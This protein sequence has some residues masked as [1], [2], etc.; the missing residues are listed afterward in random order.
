MK[1]V[2][3]S[4]VAALLVGSSA[5]AIENTKVSGDAKLLYMTTDEK[6]GTANVLAGENGSGSFF[7]KDSSAADAVF[8]LD[9]TTDLV[10]NDLVKISA[11]AGY[12]V[13]TSLGLENNLVSN[14]WGG[15][16]NATPSTGQAYGGSSH[17]D[18]LGG[19]KVDNA[20]W[21]KEAWIAATAGKTTAKLGR[22][23]VDTPLAFSE[24]WSAEVNTFEGVVA[25]NQDLPD[26]TVV[27][28]YLGNGNG[29]ETFGYDKNNPTVNPNANLQSN[30]QDLGLAVAP[31][32]N[33]NGNFGTFGTDGAYALGVVNNSFKPLNVQAWYYAVKNVAD[34]YWL[35]ADLNMEGI[36]AGAQYSGISVQKSYTGLSSD[37]DND[38]YALMLGY[39]LKDT[40]T[41]KA[42]YSQTGDDTVGGYAANV[43]Y[44]VATN[45]G[46]TKLY[47]KTFWNYGHL[48]TG[49]GTDAMKFSISSPV[50]GLFDACASYTLVDQDVKFGNEEVQEI[51]LVVKKS[52]GPLDAK[53]AYINL[54]HDNGVATESDNFNMIQAYLTL[55]F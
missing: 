43:G 26:T 46:N 50:N 36:L 12:T 18:A 17:R 35:Q 45:T 6:G 10:S 5:F 7:D 9:V 49:A 44:N 21:F 55:N 16:H 14:V 20:N 47:T 13:L 23:E 38:V 42:A 8:N 48:V 29:N 34:A 25:I 1:L 19:A 30:V 41:I 2:K 15:S 22:M 33:G 40:V 4:M 32:V 31:V 11:G 37:L 39:E 52:F 54:D 3:M 24:K 51:A 27:G 53:L 28:A